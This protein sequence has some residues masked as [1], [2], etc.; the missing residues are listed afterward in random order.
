MPS[1]DMVICRWYDSNEHYIMM[2]MLRPLWLVVAYDLLEYSYMDSVTGNLYFF[3]LFNNTRQIS[4][5]TKLKLGSFSC[6]ASTNLPNFF[7]FVLLLSFP[8]ALRLAFICKWVM[9]ESTLGRAWRD[10]CFNKCDEYYQKPFSLWWW[11]LRFWSKGRLDHRLMRFVLF[12]LCKLVRPLLLTS[13]LFPGFPDQTNLWSLYQQYFH[14]VL[15]TLIC[16]SN[17]WSWCECNQLK[18]KV[19]TIQM[20]QFFLA[21]NPHG[22]LY[23]FRISF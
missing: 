1:H 13:S 23:Q 8:S 17:V 20:N 19:K 7:P 18:S 10:K 14:P 4:L 15:F 16:S 22:S 21:G 9:S 12:Q 11:F 2:W 3:V 5:N 6:H